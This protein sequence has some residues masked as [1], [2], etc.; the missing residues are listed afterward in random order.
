MADVARVHEIALDENRSMLV[1]RACS[2]A[3]YGSFLV[4]SLSLQSALAAS[5]LLRSR[6]KRFADS[7]CTLAAR[8]RG[9]KSY[10]C[11]E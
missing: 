8:S 5:I 1:G 4:G 6:L 9:L 3:S 2:D 7:L 11:L 10:C